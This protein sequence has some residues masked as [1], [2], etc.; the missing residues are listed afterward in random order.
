M[1]VYIF[2]WR[3]RL[4]HVN[5]L[6]GTPLAH[7]EAQLDPVLKGFKLLS[8]CIADINGKNVRDLENKFLKNPLESTARDDLL[9]ITTTMEE[10]CLHTCRWWLTRRRLDF[11]F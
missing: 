11:F 8:D 5:L 9:K 2:H 7:A 3:L 4:A 1:C 10:R 6:S